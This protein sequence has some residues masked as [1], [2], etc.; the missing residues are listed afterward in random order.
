MKRILNILLCAVLCV[1]LLSGQAFAAGTV[2]APGQITVKVAA[3]KNVSVSW[4]KAADVNGYKVYRAD[5]GSKLYSCIKTISSK[6]TVKYT[7]KTVK[8]GRKY[9][10][11]VRAMKQQKM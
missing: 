10:Y 11:K 9:S 2:K 4:S 8:P 6:A 1:A 7:D 5:S 3:D